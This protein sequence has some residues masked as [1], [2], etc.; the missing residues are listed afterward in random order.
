MMTVAAPTETAAG[1]QEMLEPKN[2][3]NQRFIFF[4][5]KGGVGKTRLHQLSCNFGLCLHQQYTLQ[6]A[7]QAQF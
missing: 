7:Q 4:G 3:V 1:L 5:G 2:G 6:Q